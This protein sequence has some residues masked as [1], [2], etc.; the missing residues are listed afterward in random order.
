MSI[1]SSAACDPTSPL[2]DRSGGRRYFLHFFDVHLLEEKGA[3]RILPNVYKEMKLAIRLAL[4]Y[5]EELLIPASSYFESPLC[6]EILDDLGADFLSFRV[7]LVASGQGLDEFLGEKLRQYTESQFQGRIYRSNSLS[8]LF[9]WRARQRSAT[10]DIK[11]S[12][13]N[14]LET[15]RASFTLR[16]LGV[17]LPVDIE[18]QWDAVPEQLGELAFIVDNIFPLLFPWE[19]NVAHRNLFHSI[20]N[21]AYF[22]SYADDY[23]ASVLQNMMF[24]NTGYRIPSGFPGEDIDYGV[25]IR[26]LQR[27]GVLK[28]L[29]SQPVQTL[30]SLRDDEKFRIALPSMPEGQQFSA[31]ESG[32]LIPAQ[33]VLLIPGGTPMQR[34]GEYTQEQS[35]IEKY[36]GRIDFGIIT[37]REDEFEACLSKFKSQE[38][39]KGNAY[40]NI[41]HI[42]CT[43]GRQYKVAISRSRAQG[44]GESQSLATQMMNDLEP[45]WIILAGIGGA[46]PSD[47]YT[48]GDVVCASH[49]HD[50][51]VRAAAEDTYDSYNVAGGSMHVEIRNLLA[52]LPAFRSNLGDWSSEGAVGCQKPIIDANSLHEDRFYGSDIWRQK[53]K[54]SIKLHFP[55]L[56]TPRAPRVTSQ[57]V[58]SSDALIKEPSL[59]QQWQVAARSLAA[60]E[61]ELA[62]V[63]IAARSRGKETPVLAIRGIS[64]IV[65]FKREDNWTKYACSTAA[66]FAYSLVSSG[67]ID[68]SEK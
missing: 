56:G 24:L 19:P 14:A 21:E 32:L 42:S 27:M 44:N 20:I 5:G 61:M 49:V 31:S 8:Q 28:I 18:R 11:R 35:G 45:K 4:L 68:M 7:S 66:S 37:I 55:G 51:S 29:E 10:A 65:G 47:D 60:V 67:V 6:R 64:D 25:C 50:F 54:E 63:Y 38:F 2:S 48:L 34:S 41:A 17:D 39:V 26:R 52:Q 33:P 12:W 22:Q 62:G 9:P 57:P 59:I 46:V 36:R 23:G 15:E 58:V 3:S 16:R 30:L 1:I 43:N 53:V 40:Y 13:R